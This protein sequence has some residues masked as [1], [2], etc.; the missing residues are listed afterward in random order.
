MNNQVYL[1]GGL[2]N[3]SDDVKTNIPRYLNDL[4]TLELKT[5]GTVAWDIPATYGK[6]TQWILGSDHVIDW[7]SR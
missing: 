4:Y 7:V 2:A 5:N 6:L 3:D 1:F